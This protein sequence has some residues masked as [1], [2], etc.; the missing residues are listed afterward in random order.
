MLIDFETG[1]AGGW[2]QVAVIIGRHTLTGWIHK[3]QDE[4]RVKEK[5]LEGLEAMEE[6]MDE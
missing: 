1:K 4:E 2:K 6:W 5:M 3:D